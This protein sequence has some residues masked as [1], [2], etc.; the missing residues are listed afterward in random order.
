MADAISRR[1]RS[2]E[3]L[4]QIRYVDEGISCKAIV[5]SYRKPDLNPT[6]SG[7]QNKAMQQPKAIR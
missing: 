6:G 4:F 3:L 2:L 5:L 7:I 1:L